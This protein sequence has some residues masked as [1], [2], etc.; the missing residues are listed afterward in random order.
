MLE[1]NIT[2]AQKIE[3]NGTGHLPNLDKPD[4]FNKIV[5]E[6]LLSSKEGN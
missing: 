6:F 1:S 4:E 5:L 2:M 3:I